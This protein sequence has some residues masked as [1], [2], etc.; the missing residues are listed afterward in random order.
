MNMRLYRVNA[1]ISAGMYDTIVPCTDIEIIGDETYTSVWCWGDK[2]FTSYNQAR[3]F[4]RRVER[5][6]SN[7]KNRHNTRGCA[8]WAKLKPT[9]ESYGVIS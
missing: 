2:L 6:N 4:K 8:F 9:I 3:N 7:P 5:W 1:G